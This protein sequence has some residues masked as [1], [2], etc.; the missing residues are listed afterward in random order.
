MLTVYLLGWI[1]AVSMA[2]S[3][4]MAAVVIALSARVTD[5]SARVEQLEADGGPGILDDL[6]SLPVTARPR[7][8]GR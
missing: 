3:A 6:T 8:A 7:T 4:A 5:L 2:V 1:A